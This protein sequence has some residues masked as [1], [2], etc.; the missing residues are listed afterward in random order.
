MSYKNQTLLGIAKEL[1]EKGIPADV[2]SV[3]DALFTYSDLNDE[4]YSY[5][6]E[7]ND[8]MRTTE[9]FGQDG[10]ED[11]IGDIVFYMEEL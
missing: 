11:A 10:Y 5:L 6:C 2:E 4:L 9:C 1:K 7:S 8:G 3:H